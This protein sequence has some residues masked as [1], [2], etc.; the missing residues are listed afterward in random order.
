MNFPQNSESNSPLSGSD[1]EEEQESKRNPFGIPEGEDEGL[2][3]DYL[4]DAEFNYGKNEENS[5][6][7][8][9]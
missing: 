4:R 1:S 7:S 3:E 5:N 8:F 6:D 2:I 9:I